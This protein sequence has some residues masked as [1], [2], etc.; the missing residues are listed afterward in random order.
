MQENNKYPYNSE[1]EVIDL[2]DVWHTLTKNV[3]FIRNVTIATTVVAVAY[4]F[5]MPPTYQ[6]TALLRIK[7]QK[8]ITSSILDAM[9]MGNVQAN[10]QLISTY[11][12]ILKSRSVVEPVIKK[13]LEPNKEGKYPGYEGYVKGNIVTMPFKNTE[14]ISVSVKGKSP[15]QAKAANEALLDSFLQRLTEIERTQYAL[16]RTFIEGRVG[17]SKKDLTKAEDALNSFQ[18]EH[19]ILSPDDAVKLA[20][21]KYSM[22]DK[23]KAENKI[24]LE[25]ANAKQAAIGNSM[26][27]GAKSIADSDVVKALNAQLAKLEAERVDMATKYTQ[28]HPAMIKI[29]QDIAE[30]EGK[31]DQAIKKVASGESAST[32]PVYNSLLTEKFRSEAEASVAQ[33]NLNTIAAIEAKYG[34]DLATLSDNQKEYLRLLR[35]VTVAQEIYTML[36]KRLEE[37]KVAEV[38]ISRDVKIVDAGDL[39]ERP[40]AP[41]KGLSI[42]LGFLLGLLGSAGLVVAKELMNRTVKTTD[43]VERYL[44]LPVLG[45]IPSMES[46]DEAKEVADMSAAKKLWRAL[47]KK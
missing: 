10:A 8:G 45:Q 21:D 7:A 33:S 40:I 23:L 15:E 11:Q 6:S 37:A 5:L 4:A 13:V 22:T 35:D 31:L 39:P 42:I 41:R 47:W 46:L 2:R 38:S 36:A 3:K 28:K 17:D 14:M 43:D 16:T 27:V 18:K 20:A 24:N 29:N 19:K 26:Q 9:P 34:E 44:G 12:E 25:A 1:Q 30:L 32:N